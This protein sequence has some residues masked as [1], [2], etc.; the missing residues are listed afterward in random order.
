MDVPVDGG[1]AAVG[2][3]STT[4]VRQPLTLVKAARSIRTHVPV[5]EDI[6]ISSLL[7]EGSVDSA[8]KRSAHLFRC[9]CT[10]GTDLLGVRML[11]DSSLKTHVKSRQHA[12]CK[13]LFV[14]W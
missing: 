6:D 5:L 12:C 7:T 10:A 13:Y 1:T 9:P 14:Y 3:S 2:T 11:Q 8:G 4:G